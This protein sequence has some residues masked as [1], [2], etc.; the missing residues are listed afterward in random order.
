MSVSE[1]EPENSDHSE[2]SDLPPN[3]IPI[4]EDKDP[5]FDSDATEGYSIDPDQ[6]LNIDPPITSETLEHSHL[7][8]V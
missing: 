4:P 5:T 7:M 1:Q 3:D 2:H 6:D 8:K